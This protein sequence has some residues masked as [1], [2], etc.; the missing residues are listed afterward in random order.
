[1]AEGFIV[2]SKDLR[3]FEEGSLMVGGESRKM[4]VE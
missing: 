2:H 1:M 3:V 4:K